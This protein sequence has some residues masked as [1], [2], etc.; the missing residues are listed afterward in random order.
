[1]G[2]HTISNDISLKVTAI[3]QL[4]FELVYFEDTIQPLHYRVSLS[5]ESKK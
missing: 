3:V 4:E 1:M 5:K 2:V